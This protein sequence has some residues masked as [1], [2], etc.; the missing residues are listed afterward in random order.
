MGFKAV[1]FD[2]DG[3]LCELRF[4]VSDAKRAVI[5]DLHGLSF[6]TSAMSPDEPTQAILDKAAVQLHRR[7]GEESYGD[8][9][10]RFDQIFTEFEIRAIGL[11]KPL[12]GARSALNHL[13]GKGFKLALVTNNGVKPT[14]M[15][16]KKFGF[17]KYFTLVITR[18]DVRRMKPEGEGI[19][20]ALD[21]LR[22]NPTDALYVGDSYVDVLAARDAG[23]KV[24]TLVRPDS[25]SKILKEAPDYILTSLP[26]LIRI[27]S[28]P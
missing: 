16:L 2:L 5:E 8:V 6:D 12:W 27:V 7:R 28:G 20:V 1:I 10:S 11:T 19:R 21:R 24:A 23:V 14:N 26:G 15:I 18:A 4:Q 22:M 13:V 3:T 9:W 17:R 25:A